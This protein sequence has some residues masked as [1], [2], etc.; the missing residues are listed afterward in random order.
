M[1]R[2][3][4][5]SADPENQ[6]VVRSASATPA[7]GTRPM[8]PIAMGQAQLPV[9]LRPAAAGGDDSSS[10][11]ASVVQLEQGPDAALCFGAK[12]APPVDYKLYL[13]QV[14]GSCS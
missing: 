11:A 10:F 8:A 2:G 3:Q 14:R 9:A 1:A 13:V 6:G 12:G 5:L 7:N 4:Q